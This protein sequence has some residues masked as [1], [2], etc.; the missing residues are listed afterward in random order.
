MRLEY[1]YA[2][3][4]LWV[5]DSVS[6]IDWLEILNWLSFVPASIFLRAHEAVIIIVWRQT[7]EWTVMSTS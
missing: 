6:D 4:S 3:T 5:D 7:D 1:E 2:S